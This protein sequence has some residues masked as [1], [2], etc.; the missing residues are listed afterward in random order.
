ML[1]CLIFATCGFAKY[2]VSEG[3]CHLVLHQIKRSVKI[4]EI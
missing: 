3:L 4:G 2:D 1:K